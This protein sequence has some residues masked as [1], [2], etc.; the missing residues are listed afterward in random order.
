[1][2][3]QCGADADGTLPHWEDYA[4]KTKKHDFTLVIPSF[5]RPQ[6]LCGST[7]RYLCE[8]QVDLSKVTVFV[9]PQNAI[10]NPEPEW[11][12]YTSTLRREG[13]GEVNVRPGGV[14]LENQLIVA[15]EWAK[16]GY[17]IVMTDLVEGVSTEVRHDRARDELAPLPIDSLPA[18]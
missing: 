4:S 9:S 16:S 11:F 5:D 15:M 18:L 14:G 6:Q 10:N 1:M 13:F 7:L 2:P 12:R 8:Q 3:P 17:L